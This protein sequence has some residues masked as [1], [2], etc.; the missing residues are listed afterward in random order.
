MTLL[1]ARALRVLRLVLADVA[2]LAPGVLLYLL[3][4][5]VLAPPLP[6]LAEIAVATCFSAV[7]WLA[8]LAVVAPLR[9]RV[10]PLVLVLR[11]RV[12]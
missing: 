12:S 8:Y 5:Q 11:K 7:F 9:R 4:I 3:L 1:A 10:V 2:L 6:A